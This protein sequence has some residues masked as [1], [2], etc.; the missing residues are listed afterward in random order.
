MPTLVNS[1]VSPV[2]GRSLASGNV[3]R[4]INT[5]AFAAIRTPGISASNAASA[6][7]QLA[8]APSEDQQQTAHDRPQQVEDPQRLLP[9]VD[10]GG[11]RHARA[12]GTT[13]C[14]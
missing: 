8:P 4:N 1:V 11:C 6:P 14:R 10:L 7:G 13:L 5:I 3:R 2:V 12:R 9:H